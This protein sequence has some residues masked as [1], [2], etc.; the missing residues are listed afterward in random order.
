MQFELIAGADPYFTNLNADHNNLPYLSQDLRVFTV[1]P[2]LNATPI[3]GVPAL[4]DSVSGAYSYIQSLLS[5]W[6]S[7]TNGYSNPNGP[8]PFTS[9]FPGQGDAPG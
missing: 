2:A 5:R 8:D 7:S 3:P 4:A 1:T 6:N 9:V